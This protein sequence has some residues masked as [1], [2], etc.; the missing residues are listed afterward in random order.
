MPLLEID[1]ESFR[2]IGSAIADSFVPSSDNGA[3][4]NKERVVLQAE[5]QHERQNGGS[6]T[7]EKEMEDY[8][9]DVQLYSELSL[10]RDCRSMSFE[11][12]LAAMRQDIPKDKDGESLPVQDSTGV[13]S[14]MLE[15]TRTK[16]CHLGRTGSMAMEHSVG[17]RNGSQDR[18]GGD[19]SRVMFDGEV[20]LVDRPEATPAQV[21]SSTL[22]KADDQK[23]ATHVITTVSSNGTEHP[24]SQHPDSLQLSDTRDTDQQQSTTPPQQALSDAAG[25]DLYDRED[26]SPEDSTSRR[27][28]N[29]ELLSLAEGVRALLYVFTENHDQRQLNEC[30][31]KL[32]GAIG[33]LICRLD[34]DLSS[35]WDSDERSSGELRAI[36]IFRDMRG[37]LNLARTLQSY[38]FG[39]NVLRS[40]LTISLPES[41]TLAMRSTTLAI[42]FA[43]S[44]D[45]GAVEGDRISAWANEAERSLNDTFY[46]VL[47]SLQ[48]PPLKSKAAARPKDVIAS[49]ARG[50]TGRILRRHFA[51]W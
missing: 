2:P 40:S 50:V 13:Q 22:A 9:K 36:S 30:G 5:Q 41:F 35:P 23:H 7:V 27:S 8:L 11:E 20:Q 51:R 49:L 39:L 42:I 10:Y 14:A 34:N 24:Q 3:R 44:T 29:P 33:A 1:V 4:K 26:H 15:P 17:D 48:K 12:L 45:T 18:R 21:D 46:S 31:R 28:L 6:N 43:N 38:Q 37:L 25:D 19:S 16:N 32:C 47:R